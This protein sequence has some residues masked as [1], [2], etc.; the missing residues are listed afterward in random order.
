ME[1]QN[2]SYTQGYIKRFTVYIRL[3]GHASSKQQAR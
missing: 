3:E 1:Y 2:I